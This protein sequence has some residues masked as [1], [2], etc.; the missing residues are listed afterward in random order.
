VQRDHVEL[1]RMTAARLAPAGLLLFSTN[2]R[3]FRLDEPALAGLVVTDIT[4]ETIPQDCKRDQ[5]IHRCFE[6]SR[7]TAQVHRGAE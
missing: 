1:I 5:R 3:K 2:F 6:L 7:A 4:K